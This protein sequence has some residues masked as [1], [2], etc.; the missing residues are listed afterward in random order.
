MMTVSSFSCRHLLSH[1]SSLRRPTRRETFGFWEGR[2]RAFVARQSESP[3][4]SWGPML[5]SRRPAKVQLRRRWQLQ[6]SSWC[7]CIG[8][9]SS[10]SVLRYLLFLLLGSLYAVGLPKVLFLSTTIFFFLLM[11]Q[12][13]FLTRRK[14]SCLSSS[15]DGKDKRSRSFAHSAR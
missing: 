6:S 1:W 11:T 10:S 12:L 3:S 14:R 4:S 2:R 8:A 5:G 13:F 15:C 9:T 7:S